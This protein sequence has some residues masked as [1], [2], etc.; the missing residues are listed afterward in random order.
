MGQFLCA[1]VL[2]IVNK[3]DPA[4]WRRAIYSEWA[5]SGM[6]LI[7]W[8]ILP[9]S[10]RWLCERGRTEKARAALKSI[11]GGAKG[12]DLDKEY[13]ILETEVEDGHILAEQQKGL[14]FTAVF[15]GTNLVST[16]FISQLP[17]Q[18]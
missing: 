4:Y 5:F 6:A 9:E 13:L 11:N 15:K 10:P 17:A 12:Y 2:N 3:Q 18:L 1:V 8:L 7:V 14:A 16:T